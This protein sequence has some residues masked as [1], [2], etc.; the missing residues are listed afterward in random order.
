[1]QNATRFL[2]S[3]SCWELRLFSFA[4]CGPENPDRNNS[5][6]PGSPQF[7]PDAPIL[8]AAPALSIEGIMLNWFP[9]SDFSTSYIIERRVLDSAFHQVGSVPADLL[10][11]LDTTNIV[12]NTEYL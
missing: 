1:M 6:D 5:N 7:V 12:T 10:L 8:A 2:I 9:K 4:G 11:Y 3:V